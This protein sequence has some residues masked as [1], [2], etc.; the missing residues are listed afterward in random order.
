MEFSIAY[1]EV[2]ITTYSDYSIDDEELQEFH[3]FV[4]WQKWTST[5]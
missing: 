2:A 1:I 5:A 4:G 3:V